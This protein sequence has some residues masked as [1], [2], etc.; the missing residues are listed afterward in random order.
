MANRGR[1]IDRTTQAWVRATGRKIDLARETWL[2]GP[3][4]QTESINTTWLADEAARLGGTMSSRPDQGLLSEF[5]TLDRD[6]FASVDLHPLIV[7]FYE[8]TRRWQ[9]DV[10]SQW[11]PTFVPGAWL[12]MSVF[13]RRLQQFSLPLSPLEVSHG[14]D[15]EVTQ[16]V[17]PAGEVLGSAWQR[18]LRLTG[19][20]VYG[21][22]YGTVTLPGQQ[23]RTVRVVFPLPNGS[24]QVFLR[25]DIVDG[26]ALRL[27]SGRGR[28]GEEGAYLVVTAADGSAVAR[29]IPIT[30]TFT[31]FV[32]DDGVL[33]TDHELRLWSARVLRLH[34]RLQPRQ[35]PDH[36][37]ERA[38]RVD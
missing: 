6:G 26:N 28:F 3:V 33:R 7:D 21:G 22:W 34:Y 20:T 38:T 36:H 12:L 29:R 11:S 2:D 35:A 15:S 8:H 1:P 18:T 9:M 10:W 4:G 37:S 23:W 27:T 19:Q 16:I 13:A 5:G 25:P 17:S 30:E 32:D 14:M 24:L 31:V